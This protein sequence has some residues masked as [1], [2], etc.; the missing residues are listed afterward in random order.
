MEKYFIKYKS[1]FY[2]LIFS[3][4]VIS[5]DQITKYWIFMQSQKFDFFLMEIL[6]ILNFVNYCNRGVSFG[7]FGNLAYSM[8]IFS[9][10]SIFAIGLFIYFCFKSENKI[11]KIAF[12]LI[13]SG[14]IGNL[15]DRIH[16]GCVVD[17]I[18]FYINDMHFPAFNV[19]DSVI[20]VGGFL[21]VLMEIIKYYK[22]NKHNNILIILLISMIFM[23]SCK[24]KTKTRILQERQNTINEISK[25][26]G[27]NVIPPIIH[28]VKEPEQ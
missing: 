28:D 26:H 16:H 17:F 5:F 21:I 2:Y 14:A 11:E 15:I 8:Q 19:A 1:F 10:I 22:K 18:D 13:I 4:L 23:P 6:P 24:K 3:I 9:I 20:S 25:K 7:L 27:N 12:L